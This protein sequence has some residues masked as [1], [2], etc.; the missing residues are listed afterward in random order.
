M[1]YWRIAMMPDRIPFAI[2]LPPIMV[3]REMKGNRGFVIVQL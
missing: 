1:D 2:V 3:I